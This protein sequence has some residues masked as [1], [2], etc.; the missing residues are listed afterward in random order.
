MN[1]YENKNYLYDCNVNRDIENNIG[2]ISIPEFTMKDIIMID[3]KYKKYYNKAIRFI[4]QTYIFNEV[5]L[6]INELYIEHMHN[7]E[8][9]III[10]NEYNTFQY[11]FASNDKLTTEERVNRDMHIRTKRIQMYF[12][13]ISP[14]IEKGKEIF[15]SLIELHDEMISISR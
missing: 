1:S 6:G 9:L 14:R 10:M 12:E 4:R 2:E 3:D 15:V 7:I 11:M 8:M 13:E 5:E